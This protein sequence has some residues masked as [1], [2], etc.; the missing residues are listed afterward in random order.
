M[1]GLWKMKQNGHLHEKLTMPIQHL[2]ICILWHLQKKHLTIC[3]FLMHEGSMDW[4]DW[5]IYQLVKDGVPHW[6][7]SLDDSKRSWNFVQGQIDL[8]ERLGMIEAE[9]G[10]TQAKQKCFCL[11]WPWHQLSFYTKDW[12]YISLLCIY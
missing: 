7:Q 5:T 9:M 1:L 3:L 8:P 4:K 11:S 10:N 2:P 6:T 12:W